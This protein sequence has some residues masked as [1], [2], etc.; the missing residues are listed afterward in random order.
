MAQVKPTPAPAPVV[1]VLTTEE[2]VSAMGK[3]MLSAS[4]EGFLME[5]EI[6][7]VHKV[8]QVCFG[9]LTHNSHKSSNCL[10]SCFFVFVFCLFFF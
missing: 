3:K 4:D 9:F 2:Q 1:S 8:Y 10:I 6:H 5:E 7:T